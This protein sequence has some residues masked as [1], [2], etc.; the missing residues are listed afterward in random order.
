MANYL[1]LVLSKPPE[2]KHGCVLFMSPSENEAVRMAK[3][4]IG[5]RVVELDKNDFE[6]LRINLPFYDNHMNSKEE[7]L[8]E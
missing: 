4:H 6:F 5:C 8:N 7:P 3:N 2:G 1:Y